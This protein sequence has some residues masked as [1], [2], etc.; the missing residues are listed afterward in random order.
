MERACF[1]FNFVSKSQRILQLARRTTDIDFIA[2]AGIILKRDITAA[3]YRHFNQFVGIHSLSCGV[4]HL[5]ISQLF[6]N[7]VFQLFRRNGTVTSTILIKKFQLSKVDCDLSGTP[8]QGQGTLQCAE[9]D[10]LAKRLHFLF[11]RYGK[12]PVCPHVYSRQVICRVRAVG[13]RSQ[14]VDAVDYNIT[15]ALAGCC[16]HVGIFALG[17]GNNRIVKERRTHQIGGRLGIGHILSAEFHQFVGDALVSC[18]LPLNHSLVLLQFQDLLLIP[19]H[20]ALDHGLGIHTAGKT[21]NHIICPIAVNA[22]GRR[23]AVHK[24]GN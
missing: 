22:A 16:N 19:L 3:I 21:G 17:R 8:L 23:T 5:G 20:H 2:R 4:D 10:I 13:S 15:A 24:T 12:L 7:S 18:L 1:I 14:L 6:L 9:I 11:T